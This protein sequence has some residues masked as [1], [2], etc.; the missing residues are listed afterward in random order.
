MKIATH[1]VLFGQ[2]NWIMKNIENA[3]PHV[4]KIYIAYSEKPWGYNPNARNIYKNSF[5]LNIIK[6]SKFINKI[7]IIEGDWLTEE[8]QRNA[9]V[10]KANEDGMDYLMIHDADEFYFH[11]D[12]EK[13]K[14][15]IFNQP[16][17]DIYTCGWISFWKTFKYITVANLSNKMVGHPQIVINL[18]KGV[19]FERKRKPT[20]SQIINIPNIICYHASYVLTDNE[21]KEKLKTWGHHNDF[22]IDIWYDNIWLKWTPEMLNLHP[23]YPTAWY[24]AIKYTE[25]LPEVLK[26]FEL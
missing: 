12:F 10:N 16:S 19:K 6:Q 9:C 22:N 7:S 13:I 25:K 3:F 14:N 5:N 18:K 1:I 17:Y 2:D 26:E 24:K 4:D 8:A 15:F 20:G 21:L 11:D 23:V